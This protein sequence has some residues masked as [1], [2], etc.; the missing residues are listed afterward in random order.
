MPTKRTMI[1]NAFRDFLTTKLPPGIFVKTSR[2][3]ILDAK[4]ELPCVIVTS[5]SEE[6]SIFNQAPRQYRRTL[7]LNLEI[8]VREK[9]AI[10]DAVE[11]LMELI[12]LAIDNEDLFTL[13]GEVNEIIYRGSIVSPDGREAT[14]ESAVAMIRYE[15]SYDTDAGKVWNDAE[16][17]DEIYANISDLIDTEITNIHE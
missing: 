10:E 4:D 15:I 14:Q 6:A 13:H 5:G 11:S 3:R 17:F 9:T 16:D 1:R 8:Y 12:E 7:E 2:R